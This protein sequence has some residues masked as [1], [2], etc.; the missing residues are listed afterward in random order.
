MCVCACA[1]VRACVC[2]HVFG[3]GRAAKSLSIKKVSPQSHPFCLPDLLFKSLSIPAMH[4]EYKEIKKKKKE[5]CLGWWVMG[6][7]LFQSKC[8]YNENGRREES[9][10]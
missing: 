6:G 5:S 7:F 4:R 10:P 2:V 1:C 3:G 9:H 8:F